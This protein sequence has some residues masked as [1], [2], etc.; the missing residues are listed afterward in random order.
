MKRIL[1]IVLIFASCKKEKNYSEVANREPKQIN[2]SESSNKEKLEDYIYDFR[3]VKLKTDVKLINIDKVKY[4]NNNYYVLDKKT[5]NLLVFDKE[6][7]YIKKIGERGKGPGEYKK[8]TDFEIDEKREEI[9]ILSEPNKAM[10]KFAL[11]G[12]FKKRISFKFFVHGFIMAK[13]DTYVFMSG[14]SSS[15]YHTLTTTDLNGNIISNNI[16]FPKNIKIKSF[17]YS[18]GIHKQGVSNYFTETTS[19]LIYEIQ[20]SIIP[21]YQFNFGGDTWK[22]QDKFDL[23]RFSE[24]NKKSKISYLLNFYCDTD[25]VMAF[26]FR[27]GKYYRKGFYFKNS[28]KVL[29][30]PFNLEDSFL[31]RL[32]SSPIGIKSNNFISSLNYSL[33]DAIR[34]SKESEKFKQLYP[35]F[36]DSIDKNLKDFS[37]YDNP[38]LLIYEIKDNN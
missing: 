15:T 12:D 25:S 17:G 10:F 34:N 28:N 14:R 2:I 31:Y 33:Y 21:M 37:E 20:D 9:L 3:V 5:S 16:P 23:D 18:G 1:L 19:S 26:R 4:F 24:E 13:N 22:E 7:D 11:N 8:I 27:N 35:E 32:L 36:Q 38:Y 29:A 30:A 6:G